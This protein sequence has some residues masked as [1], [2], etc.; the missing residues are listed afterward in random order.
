MITSP[1]YFEYPTSFVFSN[2]HHPPTLQR[3]AENCHFRGAWGLGHWLGD[4]ACPRI[5][6]MQK[7][8]HVPRGRRTSGTGS[9]GC[10]VGEVTGGLETQRGA[11]APP[12][13]SGAD[14]SCLGKVSR[15][16]SGLQLTGR[17]P[18]TFKKATCFPQSPPISILTHPKSS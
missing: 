2:A 12:V 9:H 1:I 7:Q 4:S 13:L 16:Y 5:L 14:S 10:R 17:R 15:L 6:Q 11:A 8:Q 18:P 3:E